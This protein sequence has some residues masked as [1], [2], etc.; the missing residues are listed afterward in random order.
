MA[1]HTSSELIARVGD[2]STARRFREF[3]AQE[4]AATKE[5]LA[6]RTAAARLFSGAVARLAETKAAWERVQTQ[7][8]RAEAEAVEGLLGSGLQAWGSGRITLHLE[9]GAARLACHEARSSD[10]GEQ[11]NERVGGPPDEWVGGTRGAKHASLGLSLAHT[12]PSAERGRERRNVCEFRLLRRRFLP[13]S[14]VVLPR[15]D[16]KLAS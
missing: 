14:E 12:T 7:T 6:T 1:N 16:C 11:A 8:Q 10:E 2:D 4:V 3:A 5:R 9:Q 15:Q 13:S